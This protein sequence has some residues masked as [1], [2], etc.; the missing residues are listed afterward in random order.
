[1]LL[2]EPTLELVRDAVEVEPVVPLALKGKAGA[3]PAYRL[4]RVLGAPERRHETPFVGREHELALIRDAWNRAL[5]G[6]ALRARHDRRRCGRRQVAPR[7]RGPRPPRRHDRARPLPSLRRGDHL[8]ARGRGAEA[9]RRA[10]SRPGSGRGDPV[11]ARRGRHVSLGR[12]D[13]LGLPQ[14]ARARGGQRSRWSWSSTTSTGARKPSSTSSS[15][16]RFSPGSADPACLPRPSR[17]GSSAVPLARPRSAL[18]PLTETGRRRADTRP[19]TSRCASRSRARRRQ[20]ALCGA[21][22][23]RWPATAAR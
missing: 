5:C 6:A 8:L 22:C 12:G 14:D 16:S 15:T 10:A 13:R 4:L 9:A 3:V 11:A 1:M 18:E 2:G 23:W 7:R 17:A 19:S 20:P 21:R